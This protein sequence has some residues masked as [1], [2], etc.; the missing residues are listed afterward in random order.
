MTR[1]P[2]FAARLI[3]RHGKKIKWIG[4]Q[5]RIASQPRI[6]HGAIEQ[7]AMRLPRKCDKGRFDIRRW[8]QLYR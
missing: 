4:C 8:T 6:A 3:R 1:K 2:H 7:Q 5:K